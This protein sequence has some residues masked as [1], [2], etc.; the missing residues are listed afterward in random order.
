MSTNHDS[1]AF[2]SDR[3]SFIHIAKTAGSSFSQ[4]LANVLQPHYNIEIDYNKV[5]GTGANANFEQMMNAAIM[6]FSSHPNG[7]RARLVSGHF[8]YRNIR[9]LE[10]F[11]SSKLISLVRNPAER[12]LSDDR[13]QVSE[14]HPPH[15]AACARYPTFRDFISDPINKDVIFNHLCEDIAQTGEECMEFIS[16]TYTF[17]GVREMYT[18]SIKM[19]FMLLGSGVVGALFRSSRQSRERSSLRLARGWQSCVAVRSARIE[20]IAC[21]P[22]RALCA[23]GQVSIMVARELGRGEVFLGEVAAAR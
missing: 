23:V 10:E 4:E 12:L 22:L 16:R 6:A 20:K 5:T 18:F 2:N 21:A 15:E 9:D 19:M 17:V 14:Q 3:W 7:S 1:R 8:K 13:F 11:R